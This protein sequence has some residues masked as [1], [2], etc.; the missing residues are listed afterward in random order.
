MTDKN[1][2][3]NFSWGSLC[4]ICQHF[5][6]ICFFCH[7][8]QITVVTRY[9]FEL[10][11]MICH[12]VLESVRKID[13]HTSFTNYEQLFS[14]SRDKFQLSRNVTDVAKC[15]VLI[16]N[17]RE[18]F[19]L[20]FQSRKPSRKSLRQIKISSDCLIKGLSQVLRGFDPFYE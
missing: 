17:C 2:L 20:N 12:D 10:N 9:Y 1:I 11:V 3:Y 15:T 13:F 8:Q 14:Y 5:F 19:G 16:N 18:N 4:I 7:A 6:R